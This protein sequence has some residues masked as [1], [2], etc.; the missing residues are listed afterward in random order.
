MK[1]FDLGTVL[2]ITTGKLLTDIGNVYEILGYMVGG[3]LFTHQLPEASD[4]CKPV[5]LAKYP[6]LE[7]IDS[8]WVGERNWKEFLDEQI[9]L[10]GNE[11]EIE[12]L[13]NK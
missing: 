12:P 7:F 8:F 6:Q 4:V 13:Q 11:F 3:S 5:I 10:F 9:A 2:S 1:T